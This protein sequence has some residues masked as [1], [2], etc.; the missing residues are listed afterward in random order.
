MQHFLFK[1][2][3]RFGAPPYYFIR[4]FEIAPTLLNCSTPFSS[5][6]AAAVFR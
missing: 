2:R 6:L 4:Q 1:I 5:I 3:D